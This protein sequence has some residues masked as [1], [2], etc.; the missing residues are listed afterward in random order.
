MCF[1]CKSGLGPYRTCNWMRGGWGGDLCSAHKRLAPWRWS[2][3]HLKCL[4]VH[5]FQP[6][7]SH[8]ATWWFCLN[9]VKPSTVSAGTQHTANRTAPCTAGHC[10][11]LTS[12]PAANDAQ[13]LDQQQPN[14]PHALQLRQRHRHLLHHTRR[15]VWAQQSP[16]LGSCWPVTGCHPKNQQTEALRP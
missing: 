9:P 5:V 11:I 3:E 16:C 15:I 8:A 1:A 4:C 14:T 12:H 10:T 13:H 2:P 7:T 6:N